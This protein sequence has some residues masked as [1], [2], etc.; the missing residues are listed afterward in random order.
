MVSASDAGKKIITEYKAVLKDAFNKCRTQ[1]Y[2]AFVPPAAALVDNF[3]HVAASMNAKHRICWLNMNITQHFGYH[4]LSK[5]IDTCCLG[6][7]HGPTI[8]F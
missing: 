1:S 2:T 4:D 7:A 8:E 6:A 5:G 3:T